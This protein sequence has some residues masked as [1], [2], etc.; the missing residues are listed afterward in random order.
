MANT[1]IEQLPL[2]VTPSATDVL[3]I[4]SGGTTSSVQIQQVF[5]T[6]AA[7]PG[8]IGT[9]TPNAI[10]GTLIAA[11]T[12]LGTPVLKA[13][14]TSGISV[15]TSTGTT[16]MKIGVTS[17]NEIDISP[18][19]TLGTV[20]INPGGSGT[21]DNVTIGNTTPAP[22]H[23][24]NLSANGSLITQSAQVSLKGLTG[25]NTLQIS[26]A[27]ATNNPE[28]IISANDAG[29]TII[30]N[31]TSVGG[32]NNAT[33]IQF[34]GN[35]G[36]IWTMDVL[37]NFFPKQGSAAMTSGFSFIAGGNG[38]PTGVPVVDN[39]GVVPQYFDQTNNKLYCYNG[40]WISIN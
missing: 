37:G 26:G 39:S 15:E 36:T 16:L 24:T 21:M 4:E 5:N 10:E 7:A 31:I 9:G 30:V 3:P 23:A 25:G 40:S 8:P 29:S 28:L 1:T 32:G 20:V 17:A 18:P 19:G 14:N 11:T 12:T 22:V 13:L 34:E 6:G 35:S 2:V 38:P 33:A 27:G